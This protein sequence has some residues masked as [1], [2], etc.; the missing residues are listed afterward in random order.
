MHGSPVGECEP[1]QDACES[2]FTGT[3]AA[4]KGV[5]F[6]GPQGEIKVDQNGDVIALY[7]SFDLQ[8]RCRIFHSEG[9]FVMRSTT[10][11]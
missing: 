1:R 5:N 3:V 9:Y 10:V 8:E 6:S 11:V 7:K 2:G 4:D